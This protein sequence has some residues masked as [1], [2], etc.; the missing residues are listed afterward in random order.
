M[1]VETAAGLKDRVA[2]VTGAAR[3]IGQACS[4][5]FAR[6]GV[7]VAVCD[8]LPLDQTVERIKKADGL[9]IGKQVDVS[10]HDKL[11]LFVH[12][13]L[14]YFKRV[15]ILVTCAAICPRTDVL[16]SNEEEWDNVFKINVKGTFFTIQALLP[17]MMKSNYGKIICI[18]SLAAQTGG[19]ISGPSYV[20]AKGAIHS[21]VKHLAKKMA[22]F[23]IYVNC[24][25]PGMINTEMI[26]EFNYQAEWCPLKKI[27]EPEDIAKAVLFLASDESK[28]ITGAILNVNGGIL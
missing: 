24:I 28:Y 13:T 27:G 17:H 12:E 6:A 10:R 26:R 15:D 3:G 23:G 19:L 14:D 20:A 2:I 4:I 18:G 5:E 1:D 25:A 22:P 7:K 8:I 9:S 16:E 11:E 21:L